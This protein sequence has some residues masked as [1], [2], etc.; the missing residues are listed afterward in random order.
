[1]KRAAVLGKGGLAAHACETI[2]ALPETTLD[3]VVP[4]A[5]EPDWDIRLSDHVASR[6]PATRLVRS[7]DWRDLGGRFD[8]VFSILYDR[9]IGPDLI[10]RAERIINFHPGRLPQYRGVRP[11]NWA[12]HNRE[13]LHGVTIHTIDPGVDT[14]PI[15]AEALFSIWPDTDEVR[16]VWQRSM[17]HGR[18]LITDTLPRL[19]HI[20]PRPQNESHAKTHRSR[21]NHKLGDRGD[22]TRETSR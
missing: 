9:I 16:D 2:A 5:R 18:L 6:W 8:L 7:G 15:L 14:G 1:M 19:D 3:T 22:W 21:D 12:L 13:H 17:R 20:V 11:V 10:A 4:V